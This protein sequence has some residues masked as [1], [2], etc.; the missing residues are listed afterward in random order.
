MP[1]LVP[2]LPFLIPLAVIQLILMIVALVHV[3]THDQYK[4]G[5]KVLWILVVIF[6]N[7]FGPIIYFVIGKADE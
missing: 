6:V 4:T 1:D 3:L 7:I 2:Y 5:T